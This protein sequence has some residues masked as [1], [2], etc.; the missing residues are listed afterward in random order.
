M[1]YKG[2]SESFPAEHKQENV[3]RELWIFSGLPEKLVTTTCSSVLTLIKVGD[4]V[5]AMS[6]LSSNKGSHLMLTDL[7]GTWQVNLCCFLQKS[8]AQNRINLLANHSPLVPKPNAPKD[9]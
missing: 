3:L 2:Q 4:F 1:V 5:D 8:G 6:N 7:C 9:E